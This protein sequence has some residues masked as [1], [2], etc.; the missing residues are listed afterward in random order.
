MISF[1]I[2]LS[3]MTKALLRAIHDKE[4][5]VLFSL[6]IVTLL[7]GTIFYSTVEGFSLIDALYFS[8][9][10]LTTVGYGDLSPQTDFGKIF[11]IIYLIAGVGIILGFINKIADNIRKKD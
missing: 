11:T 2:T 6:T 4:F 3:R 10:T 5:Q 1:F 7:S 9:I 8:V